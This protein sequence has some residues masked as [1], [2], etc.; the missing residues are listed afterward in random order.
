MAERKKSK[1]FTPLGQVIDKTLET[2]RRELNADLC[3][4]WEVWDEIAGPMAIGT[5]RPAAFKGK[6]LL[7]HAEDSVT[8][9]NLGF[10]KDELIARI[11]DVLDGDFVE[12]LEFRIGAVN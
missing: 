1:R 4:V 2:Y 8:L 3:R 11:N 12:E 7:I 5:A 6:T 10:Q 9:H